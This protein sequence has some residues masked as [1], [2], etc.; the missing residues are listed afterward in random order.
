[1]APHFQRLERVFDDYID[2]YLDDELAR[3]YTIRQ[4]WSSCAEKSA[5]KPDSP[6]YPPVSIG[7]AAMPELAEFLVSTL[8]EACVFPGK[9]TASEDSMKRAFQ[10]TDLVPDE[11]QRMVQGDDGGGL[12]VGSHR[13]IRLGHEL[14]EMI[15]RHEFKHLLFPCHLLPMKVSQ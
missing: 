8:I 12:R 14:M 6:S 15:R 2:Y 3:Q 4:W 11:R 5:P 13:T 7:D 9:H 1:L 10:L